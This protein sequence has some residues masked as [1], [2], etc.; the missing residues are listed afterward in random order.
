MNAIAVAVAVFSHLKTSIDDNC[1]VFTPLSFSRSLSHATSVNVPTSRH[2]QRPPHNSQ[3]IGLNCRCTRTFMI[4]KQEARNQL[5]LNYYRISWPH[6]CT[7]KRNE[8]TKGNVPLKY[9]CLTEFLVI[10]FSPLFLVMKPYLLRLSCLLT[11]TLC[12]LYYKNIASD[13]SQLDKVFHPLL[14]SSLYRQSTAGKDV[15]LVL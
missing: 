5:W 15:I 9:I 11:A 7:K 14:A 4:T 8:L 10:S 6:Y 13:L 1:L 12:V 2:L 3:V